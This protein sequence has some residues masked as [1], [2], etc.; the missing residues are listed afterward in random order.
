MKEKDDNE[1]RYDDIMDLP[2]RKSE[3]RKQMSLHDRAA[4]FAPFAALNGHEE[5]IEET[6]RLTDREI[7]PDESE[8]KELDEKLKYL[9][10]NREKKIRVSVTYFQPDIRKQGGTYLTDVGVIGKLDET[11]RVIGM[12][13][14]RKIPVSRIISLEI[15]GQYE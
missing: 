7:V 10:E 14:G 2:Y 11:E 9:L 13:N 6:A 4:Q 1:H 15:S 3:R 5:A 12:E 8:L